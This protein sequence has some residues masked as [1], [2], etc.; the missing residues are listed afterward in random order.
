MPKQISLPEPEATEL[1]FLRFFYKKVLPCL[2][3]ADSEIVN[4]IKQ[5]FT[6][7]TGKVIAEEY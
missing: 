7:M 5:E 2:G 6:K 3:P 1:E 4:S